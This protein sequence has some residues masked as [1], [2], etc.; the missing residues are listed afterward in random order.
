MCNTTTLGI[1]NLIIFLC[2]HFP[3]Q[4]QY[5][6]PDRRGFTIGEFVMTPNN[7]DEDEA[8]GSGTG[9]RRHGIATKAT[10]AFLVTAAVA[11]SIWGLTSVANG[12]TRNN[13]TAHLM[14]SKAKVTKS[15]VMKS[16]APKGGKGEV[17]KI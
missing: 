4:P 10:K 17:S 11:G 14:K 7:E 6:E 2:N 5:Q 15:P 16:K 12:S 9:K 3:P 8:A 1:S 13:A